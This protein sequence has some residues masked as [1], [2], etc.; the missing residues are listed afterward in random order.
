MRLYVLY[1]VASWKALARTPCP[2]GCR[3]EGL[4][5]DEA[6]RRVEQALTIFSLLGWVLMAVVLLFAFVSPWFL[7]GLPALVLIQWRLRARM[8]A[9][10]EA[11]AQAFEEQ[12]DET[13]RTGG[14]APTKRRKEEERETE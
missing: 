11:M 1:A 14:D 9:A 3:E 7:L 4:M 5:I 10:R 6:K 2:V 12:H 8:E 13:T